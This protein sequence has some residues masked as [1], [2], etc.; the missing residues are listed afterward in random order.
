M[1]LIKHERDHP[2]AVKLGELPG[3]SNIANDKSKAENYEVHICACGLSGHKP[4]C[5]GSH[6]HAQKEEE[7]KV[8]VYDKDKKRLDVTKELEKIAEQIPNEY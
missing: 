6:M 8:F 7:G 3:F 4:F 1:R 5:D 2:F